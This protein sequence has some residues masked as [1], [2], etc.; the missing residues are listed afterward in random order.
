[1]YKALYTSCSRKCGTL[2][3]W[4]WG[5]VISFV[6]LLRSIVRMSLKETTQWLW[7]IGLVIPQIL[8]FH[9]TSPKF[10]LRNYHFFW[11]STLMWYYS[12]LKTFIQTNCRFKRPGCFVLRHWS[13]EIPDFCMTQHLADGQK[14]KALMWVKNITDFGRFCY[15]CL[16]INITLIFMSSSSE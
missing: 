11:A 6:W 12:T 4:S 7:N 8:G 9:V 15:S 1:M 16:R 3:T 2:G 10:K 5:L 14:M 13:L